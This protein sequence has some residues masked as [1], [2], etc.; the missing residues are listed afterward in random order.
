LDDDDDGRHL[1]ENDPRRIDA[2]ARRGR[3]FVED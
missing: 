1:A 3:R 2:E